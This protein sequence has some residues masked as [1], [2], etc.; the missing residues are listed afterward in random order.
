[1]HEG[2]F[3][4]VNNTESVDSQIE[5]EEAALVSQLSSLKDEVENIDPETIPP[6]QKLD[7]KERA[8]DLFEKLS[9]VTLLG[10]ASLDA[11]AATVDPNLTFENVLQICVLGLAG[12]IA[13]LNYAKKIDS[14]SQHA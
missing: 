9:V 7:F 14:R 4:M 11:L 6:E 5:R 13:A 10:R 8:K 12:V 1:M 3:E 2:N